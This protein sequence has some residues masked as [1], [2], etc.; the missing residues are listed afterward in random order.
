MDKLIDRWAK[1]AHFHNPLS[2]LRLVLEKNTT[3]LSKYSV[4][5]IVNLFHKESP[6]GIIIEQARS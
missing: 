2:K 1:D 3:K 4:Y 6:I 5:R